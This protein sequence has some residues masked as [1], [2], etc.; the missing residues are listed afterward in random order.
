MC[1]CKLEGVVDWFLYTVVAVV[2][3]SLAVA[4]SLL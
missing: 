1:K 2:C 4:I 3:L